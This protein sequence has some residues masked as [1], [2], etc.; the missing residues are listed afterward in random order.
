MNFIFRL[1]FSVL[2]ALIVCGTVYDV[3]VHNQILASLGSLMRNGQFK[4][5]PEPVSP[6]GEVNEHSPLLIQPGSVDVEEPTSGV[7]GQILLC[8]SITAN[9][10]K[11]LAVEVMKPGTLT[12]VHG[13]RLISMSWVILGHTIVFMLTS[14]KN[15]LIFID[16]YFK[17]FSFQAIMNASVSVDTFFLLSGTLASYLML[18]QIGKSGGPRNINW[19][20][21]F[22]HRFWRLTPAYMLILGFYTTLFHHLGT[23]PVYP[24]TDD[25]NCMKNWWQ[26][27]LY[28]NNLFT[29]SEGCMGWMWYLANDMQF[30]I[31]SPLIIIALY[32]WFVVGVVIVGALILMNI[33][34][35][36]I[37]TEKHNYVADIGAFDTN[38]TG[39]N[40]L[41][42]TGDDVSWA[43]QHDKADTGS[44][45]EGNEMMMEWFNNVYVRPYCRVGVYAIGIGLGYLL[46]HIPSRPRIR[47]LWVIAGWL[48]AALCCLSALYG[49]YG[50]SSNERVLPSGVNALYASVH[51]IVWALGVSWVIF[52]CSTGYGGPVNTLLSWSGLVPLSRFTYMAYLIHPM[53]IAWVYGTN[54]APVYICDTTII[55]M[56]VA[57]LMLSYALAFILSVTLESPLIALEKLLLPQKN[58]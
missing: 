20:L 48:L 14:M 19:A 34:V 24:E 25:P 41:D 23:G 58:R 42:C 37:L 53:V 32:N 45:K 3:L 26:N 17:R 54:E 56:F 16:D 51:R 44:D 46:S 10:K 57:N 21:V 8:F 12:A 35:V 18:K 43:E 5:E 52:A 47:V 29:Q 36:W 33:L 27:L 31:I 22:S 2:G 55:C 6:E 49:L 7:A 30:F 13:I 38:R 11:I 15:P 1:L 4:Q 40:D 50:V 9:M 28:I 39:L